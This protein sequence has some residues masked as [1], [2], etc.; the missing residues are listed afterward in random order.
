ME[1]MPEVSASLLTLTRH[2]WNVPV[3]ARL[4][5]GPAGFTA[6]AEDLSA[7]RDSLSRALKALIVPGWVQRGE[8]WKLTRTGGRIAKRCA[9][10]ATTAR[11]QETSSVMYKRW[12]LPIAAALTSWS[13]HFNELR[14]MLPG[15]S[16][17]ALTLALK[18]LQAAGLVHREI[19]GG[20]PPAAAYHLTRQ[21][22]AFVPPLLRL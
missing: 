17:R 22:E 20:F 5:G 6:L 19:V 12:S 16:P 3:M 8:T 1:I 15:I 21:G 10:I 11:K 4:G 7:S 13:L 9:A 2:R 18:E 14:L